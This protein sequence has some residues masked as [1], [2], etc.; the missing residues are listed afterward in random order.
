[1]LQDTAAQVVTE[2]GEVLV[3]TPLARALLG[4]LT[5]FTGLAR[6][7][8]YRWYTDV[9]ARDIYVRDDHDLHGRV[10]TAELRAA[11]SRQGP[12]SRAAALVEAL[13]AES[14][15]FRARWAQHEVVEKAT[16]TKR[17]EHREV[18]RLT[19]DCQTLLDTQTLQRLLVFTA[20]PGTEDAEKLALLAVIGTQS[21]TPAD[22]SG[23][24]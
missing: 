2:T 18:G 6:S 9:P 10:F 5:R 21:L 15:E 13:T 16:R 17:Y 11:L 4:D 24:S 14:P 20:Q 19:L 8:V 7:T 22:S 1:R 3:Q 23:A 12:G